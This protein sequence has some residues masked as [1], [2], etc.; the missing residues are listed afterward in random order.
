MTYFRDRRPSGALED[1]WWWN[2]ALVLMW[3]K[4]ISKQQV[5]CRR[6]VF[7]ECFLGYICETCSFSDLFGSAYCSSKP[8]PAAKPHFPL[9]GSG[10]HLYFCCR[11]KQN[12][13]ATVGMHDPSLMS[14]FSCG[15]I[16]SISFSTKRRLTTNGHSIGMATMK[17][18]GFC[19]C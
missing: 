13:S 3:A 4:M 12:L 10:C 7:V 6:C 9:S 17:M 5:R 19:E 18:P 2:R 14:F 1:A 11:P 15:F 16:N 8:N